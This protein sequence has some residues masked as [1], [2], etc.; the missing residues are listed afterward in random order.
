[1][2]IRCK[3]CHG[4]VWFRGGAEP[5]VCDCG[6]VYRVGKALSEGRLKRL[7]EDA[8]KLA[9]EHDVDLPAAYSIAMGLMTAEQVRD[10]Q[11]PIETPT[12]EQESNETEPDEG[13]R[14][15]YDRGFEQ[16]VEDGCL[17][18]QQ[19]VER[20]NREAFARRIKTKHGLSERLAYAVADNRM[21]VLAAL[22]EQSNLLQPAVVADVRSGLAWQSWAKRG[23]AATAI[24]LVGT[25][26]WVWRATQGS[27]EAA[28]G[29]LLPRDRTMQT[30]AAPNDPAARTQVLRAATQV[31]LDARGRVLRIEGPDPRSVA[32][33]F[34]EAAGPARRL[35]VLG[36]APSSPPDPRSRL[37]VLRDL[38]RRSY[39]TLPIRQETESRRW[40]AGNG[41]TP[42]RPDLASQAALSAVIER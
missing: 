18:P 42:I 15:R 36:V 32:I 27:D 10:A 23:I 30:T 1:V 4:A 33:A 6:Q 19:A 35:Q 24:A 37:A 13:R 40:V 34:G 12:A 25:G 14:I 7:G 20:G 9:R 26:V 17:T 39:H 41:M 29:L 2:Y 11:R 16:A 28:S 31:G 3:R 38:D 22:R 5:D 21:T 8:R